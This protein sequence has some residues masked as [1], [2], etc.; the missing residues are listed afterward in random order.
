MVIGANL[1]GTAAAGLLLLVTAPRTLFA[2]GGT[3]A[4]LS[5]VACLVFVRRALKNEESPAE[6]GLSSN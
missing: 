2:L 5:G 6:A 4:L 1:I 3:G